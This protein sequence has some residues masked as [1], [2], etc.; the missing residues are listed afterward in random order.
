M[1]QHQSYQII[2]MH[3]SYTPIHFFER[4]FNFNKT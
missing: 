2:D 4:E 1:S 3:Q